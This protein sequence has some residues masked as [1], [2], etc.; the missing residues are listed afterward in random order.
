MPATHDLTGKVFGRLTALRY[1]PGSRQRK[2][3]WICRCSC[4]AE[5]PVA[6]YY[7]LKG[8]T[9]SCGCWRREVSAKLA[10][11]LVEAGL[12]CL[13]R[14]SQAVANIRRGRRQSV[15][16]RLAAQTSTRQYIDGQPAPL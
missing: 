1:K 6:T 12:H 15:V 7:L 13:P 10:I 11:A 16:R 3:V 4:G 5:T 9:T 8:R 2:G 14:S